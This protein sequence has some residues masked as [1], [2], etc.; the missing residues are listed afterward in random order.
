MRILVKATKTAYIVPYS[1]SIEITKVVNGKIIRTGDYTQG[2]DNPFMVK[3]FVSSPKGMATVDI[4]GVNVP[5]QRVMV[6]NNDRDY[7][8]D[9]PLKEADIVLLPINPLS[10]GDDEV[11]PLLLDEGKLST[12]AKE[13]FNA[14][15]VSNIAVFDYHFRFTITRIAI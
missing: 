2:Y 15:R 12:F 13:N 1:D 5:E 4:N 11:L 6:V 10:Q 14:Y 9:N 3:A 8:K 7:I